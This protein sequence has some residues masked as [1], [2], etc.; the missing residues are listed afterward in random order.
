MM[1]AMVVQ[2]ADLG[3]GGRAGGLTH[4]KGA[5]GVGGGEED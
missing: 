3:R 1:G 4:S 5:G 2:V